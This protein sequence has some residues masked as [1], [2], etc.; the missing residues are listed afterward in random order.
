MLQ[1]WGPEHMF[2]V[3]EIFYIL[4]EVSVTQ[5]YPFAKIYQMVHLSYMHFTVYTFD[6][7]KT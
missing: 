1:G 7:N 5:M 6:L 2:W 4:T 3:T